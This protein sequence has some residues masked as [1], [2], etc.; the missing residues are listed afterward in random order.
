M[1]VIA[2]KSLRLFA[3]KHPRALVPLKVWCK[4]IESSEFA[5][6]ADLK[7]LFGSNVDFLPNNVVIFDVGGNKYRISASIRYRLNMLFIRDVM[8]HAEYD[9]R[10]KGDSL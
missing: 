8:T 2:W 5:D 7:R 9:R 1:R 3:Q 6:P 10:T 4:L